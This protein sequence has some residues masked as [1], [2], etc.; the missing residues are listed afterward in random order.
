[1]DIVILPESK[2]RYSA[3]EMLLIV[4]KSVS[5]VKDVPLNATRSLGGEEI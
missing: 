4:R 1:V 3:A 2:C 5:K